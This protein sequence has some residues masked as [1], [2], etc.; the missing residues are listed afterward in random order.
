[1]PQQQYSGEELDRALKD[2]KDELLA[3]LITEGLLLERAETIF[4]IDKI[5]L[6]LIEDF[7]KQ[8]NIAS[9]QEL[10]TALKEQGMTRRELEDHLMRMAVPNEIINYDVKRKISV[11][12][13]ELKDYYDKHIA[14]WETPATVTLR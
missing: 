13:T 6:S 14:R 10:E 1:M 4:D 7:R 12:E 5:R 3:N 9:D 11:S 8:Q 2:A